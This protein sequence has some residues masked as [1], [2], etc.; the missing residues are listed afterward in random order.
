MTAFLAMVRKDLLLFRND[1]RA[2]ILSFVAPIIIGGFFGYIFGGLGGK[3][4]VNKVHVLVAD[5]D[6]SDVSRDIVSRLQADAA[7]DVRVTSAE[8]ARQ[9]VRK[10]AAPAAV[11]IPKD[12]GTQS[13]RALFSGSNKPDLALLF[14]PSHQPEKGMV[15]G[16]LTGTVMQ[17]VM[18][19]S[20]GGSRMGAQL[21]TEQLDRVQNAPG[22]S[23]EQRSALTT[24]LKGVQALPVPSGGTNA[25]G[26]LTLPV[27]IKDEAVTARRGVEYNGYAHSFG[28][29]GVQF[30]LMAGLDMGIA[31]LLQRQRGLWKRFRA[32][33]LSRA[34]LLGSRAASAALISVFVLTFDFVVARLMF[35]VHIE[36]PPGFALV[37]IAFALMNATF[38]LMVAA[39]GTTPEATRGMTAFITVIM[40]MLGGAWVPTFIFPEWLQKV[41]VI[42]PTRWAIDG[43]DG[44]VWRGMTTSAALVPCAVLLGY[45][46]VFGAIAVSRFRWEA[47]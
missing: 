37:V 39:L 38:G 29:M 35:G 17:S 2:M 45:A 40:V 31:I 15:Q 47:E 6:S 46:L 34:L 5:E 9:Q 22:L 8:D 32:A 30:I 18:R 23:A 3:A 27:N 20:F 42:I 24:L 36:N 13:A 28:G 10:G 14:D 19:Q 33:P 7:L 25:G 1:R 12:F 26:G 11:V 41:T 21:A 16:M 4:P 43:L 44:V